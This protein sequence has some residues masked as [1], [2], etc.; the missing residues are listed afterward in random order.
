MTT[1][2]SPGFKRFLAVASLALAVPLT[3]SAMPYGPTGAGGCSA[4]GGQGKHGA[5]AGHHGMGGE[6]SP[7][8]LRGL[9]LT[10]VQR[11]KLFEIMHAQAPA[12]WEKGK[13]LSKAEDDLRKLASAPDYSEARAKAAADA[14]GK[15]TFELTLAHARTER[16]VFEMLTP[17]QRQQLTE[18]KASPERPRA[19]M[20][21]GMAGE[22][23]MPAPR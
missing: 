4:M 17:E 22:G 13:A 9:D 20:R 6:F 15:A 3:V 12:M 23:R 14:V 21:R 18:M 2:T 5:H 11:D 10:E 8:Y 7:R 1:I 16:Q 19:E